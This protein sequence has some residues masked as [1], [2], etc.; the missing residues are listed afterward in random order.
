[1]QRRTSLKP[2]RHCVQDCRIGRSVGCAM[3]PHTLGLPCKGP[4]YWVDSCKYYLGRGH[5]ELTGSGPVPSRHLLWPPP[6][7]V[8][9]GFAKLLRVPCPFLIFPK[10]SGPPSALTHG[11]TLFWSFRVCCL[12][13]A[14]SGQ[15][16]CLAYCPGPRAISTHWLSCWELSGSGRCEEGLTE[17]GRGLSAAVG[18]Q[19]LSWAAQHGGPAR[20]SLQGAEPE[21]CS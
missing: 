7:L 17:A 6:N 11:D 21:L 12:M 20:P 18:K 19:R 8:C 16:T 1:M 14:P 15:N 10:N 4:S 5:G 9:L 3:R 2:W 13:G